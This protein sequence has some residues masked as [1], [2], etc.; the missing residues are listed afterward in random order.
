MRTHPTAAG[1]PNGDDVTKVWGILAA[2]AAAVLGM[3]ITAPAA[4]ADPA[5][6]EAAFFAHVNAVRASEGKPPLQPDEQ[7]S[8][9]ARAW[10]AEM[11]R[12]NQL[13]HNPNLKRQVQGWKMLGENVGTGS[14][15]A[16]ITQALEKSPPHRA[17]MVN[18][19]FTHLGVGVVEANG[20]VWVT[21]VFK[22]ASGSTI[23]PAAPVAA[24]KPAAPRVTTPP[25]PRAAAAPRSAPAPKP[26]ARTEVKSEAITAPPTTLAPAPV[27][28]PAPVVPPAPA[29]QT[30]LRR[31][32]DATDVPSTTRY[33]LNGMAAALLGCVLYTLRRQL[34]VRRD[35]STIQTFRR[36][37]P[38]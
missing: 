26:A 11:A 20:A 2:F 28:E 25:R 22:Q 19:V 23:K 17:N 8:D 6:S 18:A 27:P 34:E 16:L 7:A 36:A 15:V 4:S 14:N 9:V 21:E 29:P 24:P 3:L 12:A 1:L 38:G 33:V 13:S 10:S 5:S 30:A 31:T 37:V 32:A 35:L